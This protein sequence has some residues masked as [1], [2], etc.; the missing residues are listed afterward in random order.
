MAIRKRKLKRLAVFCA[1]AST[2][3][4]LGFFLIQMFDF[5]LD[6]P[7]DWMNEDGH[8]ILAC[9]AIVCFLLYVTVVVRIYTRQRVPSPGFNGYMVYAVVLGVL[10]VL[11]SVALLMQVLNIG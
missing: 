2:L 4:F 3:Y 8:Y 11:W 7:E 6:L 5:G 10:F 9:L 1:I